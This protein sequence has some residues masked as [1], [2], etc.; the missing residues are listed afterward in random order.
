[1]CQKD[2]LCVSYGHW[3]YK[4]FGMINRL[5]NVIHANQTGRPSNKW[6][7]SPKWMNSTLD[8]S[9]QVPFQRPISCRLCLALHL[10]MSET[11]ENDCWWPLLH[12]RCWWITPWFCIKYIAVSFSWARVESVSKFISGFTLLL[13]S[14]TGGQRVVPWPRVRPSL[15]G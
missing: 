2:C 12:Y 5:V 10:H 1:M 8:I 3:I 13:C 11:V 9:S 7:K 15:M 4:A 6:I 14:Q